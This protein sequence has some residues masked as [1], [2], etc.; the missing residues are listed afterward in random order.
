MDYCKLFSSTEGQV[1]APW[2]HADGEAMLTEK[3]C[4]PLIA[5][6]PTARWMTGLIPQIISLKRKL[7]TVMLGIFLWLRNR[8]SQVSLAVW[9]YRSLPFLEACMAPSGSMKASSQKRGVQG[10]SSSGPPGP[11]SEMHVSSAIGTYLPHLGGGGGDPRTTAV[12]YNILGVSWTTLTINT[13][14]MLMSVWCWDFFGSMA[15]WGSIISSDGKFV[16]K[17]YMESI[18]TDSFGN[19]V[20][21][22]G[23]KQLNF[24]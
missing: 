17:S 7:D 16:F 22:S 6:V 11:V 13:K 9:D 19:L 8:G 24:S 14:D 2:S 20:L 15:L 4:S 18:V 5:I 12:A 3:A 21:Q 23:E 1:Y 10:R